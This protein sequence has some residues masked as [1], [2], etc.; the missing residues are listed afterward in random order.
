[1]KQTAAFRGWRLNG[2]G[3]FLNDLVNGLAVNYNRYGYYLCPC[4]DGE[5]DRSSDAD[6][7]CPCS[8]LE[9][10]HR[11]YGHCF[12]G[13]FLAPEYADS[14]ASPEPIPERRFRAQ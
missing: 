2:D 12:C 6:I 13:L 11:E 4:R 10:D 9:A 3:A 14:G 7:I 1:M 5:G 8:Y